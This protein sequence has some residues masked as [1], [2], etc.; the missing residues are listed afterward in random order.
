MRKIAILG[1]GTVGSGVAAV[2]ENSRREVARKLGDEVEVAAVLDLRDFPGD[3]IQKKIVHDFSAVVSNPEIEVVAEVMGGIHPAYEFV[4]QA[5]AAGKHVVTSNKELVEA[6]GAELGEIARAHQVSFLFEASVAGGIPILRTINTAM[7]QEEIYR[8]TG[9]LNGTTNY[10]LEL[11]EN[12]GASFQE[13]LADAQA[14]GYAERKP[15]ADVEGYDAS[16]KIA[17][18]ASMICGRHI[19]YENVPTQG[20]SKI[21]SEDIAAATALG[22]RLKLISNCQKENGRFYASVE[23]MFVPGHHMLASVNSVYNAVM[24]KSSM[25]SDTMYYGKGAGKLATASAVVADI[26]AALNG[27][28]RL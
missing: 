1:Y 24:V 22:G 27:K 18:L 4:S 21:T 7:I 9:I 10:I 6:R 17:I 28:R 19:S 2:L 14:K 20:I 15:E 8:I 5:L 3:P 12:A 16:R 13:A 23:P 25:L 26:L 11:M